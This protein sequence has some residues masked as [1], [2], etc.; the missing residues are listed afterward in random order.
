MPPYRLSI[1]PHPGYLGP[2][3]KQW[4]SYMPKVIPV[5]AGLVALVLST[6]AGAIVYGTLDSGHPNVGA[7]LRL[8]ARADGTWQ[9]CSGTLIAP[10]VFLTAAHCDQGLSRVTVTFDT[11]YQ[12]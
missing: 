9:T 5:A 1:P 8:S 3:S 11:P 12:A 2:C 10:N 4:G 7:L 6:G